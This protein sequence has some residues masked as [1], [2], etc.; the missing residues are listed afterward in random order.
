MEQLEELVDGAH[1]NV[2]AERE[3]SM[4]PLQELFRWLDGTGDGI[5]DSGKSKN[6][7]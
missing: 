6:P 4:V 2:L 7:R 1:L 5:M 3:R